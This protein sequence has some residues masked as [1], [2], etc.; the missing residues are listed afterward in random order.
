MLDNER[1]K[2]EKKGREK[3]LVGG[4]KERKERKL[5]VE[6]NSYYGVGGGVD[7]SKNPEG[8][9]RGNFRYRRPPLFFHGVYAALFPRAKSGVILGVQ[10]TMGG[11]M[12]GLYCPPGNKESKKARKRERELVGRER[13]RERK[14]VVCNAV[15]RYT[16]CGSSCTCK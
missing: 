3:E 15:R 14:R 13:K 5:V 11:A 10:L 4:G 12:K 1:E 16:S 2:E 6:E 8:S 7:I 9:A